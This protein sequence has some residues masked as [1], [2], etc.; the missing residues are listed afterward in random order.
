MRFRCFNLKAVF[1]VVVCMLLGSGFGVSANAADWTI[2]VYMGADNNLSEAAEKDIEEMRSATFGSAVNVVVLAE[3]SNQYSFSP[4]AYLSDYNT[5]LLEISGQTVTDVGSGLG[6]LNMGEPAT[7]K[8]FIQNVTSSYPATRYALIIWD[9]GDGW[10]NTRW[11]DVVKRGAVEDQ[12]SSSFMT[13]AQLSQGVQSSGVKMDLIDFDACLMAMYEVAYEFIGLADY[14]VF[15]EDVEPGDGNPYTPIL[16]EL[17][18]NPFMTPAVLSQR[19]VTEFANSYQGGRESVTKSAVD[20]AE[21]QALHTGLQD[22]AAE[23][24]GIA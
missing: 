23:L 15:S 1:A 2:M 21:I 17:G 16:N 11:P 13:L 22:L 6:N 3:L 4:P 19:I 14:L 20:M 10:R 7:L 24:Q 9:H 18:A 12:T 8:W 5:H